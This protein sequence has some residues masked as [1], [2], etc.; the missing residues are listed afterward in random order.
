MYVQRIQ[1]EHLTNAYS[2]TWQSIKTKLSR[3]NNN[4]ERIKLKKDKTINKRKQQ[5]RKTKL[6]NNNIK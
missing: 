2:Y 4:Q 5:S 3:K 1:E 6:L